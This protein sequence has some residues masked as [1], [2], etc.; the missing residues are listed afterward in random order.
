MDGPLDNPKKRAASRSP[1]VSSSQAKQIKKICYEDNYQDVNEHVMYEPAPIQAMSPSAA[2][3]EY[4]KATQACPSFLEYINTWLDTLYPAAL[5]KKPHSGYQIKDQDCKTILLK[6]PNS[7]PT[8]A[9]GRTKL[10][11][12]A[13]NLGIS[14][15]P[16]A[17]GASIPELRTEE[18]YSVAPTPTETQSKF[19]G[20]LVENPLYRDCNLALNN[21]LL[22]DSRTKL[23]PHLVDLTE[24]LKKGRSSPEPEPS[25]N[26]DLYAL[27]TVSNEAK[28]EEFVRKYVIPP[29]S[30]TGNI[31]RSDRVFVNRKALPATE[32]HARL[33]I[34][35]P[36]LLYGYRFSAFEQDHRT[37]IAT[38]GNFA[39]A[40]GEGL[41]FPF[42]SIEFKG[43]GPSSRGRL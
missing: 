33:S 34:P 37:E 7:A 19:S 26:D 22:L 9:S 38:C 16:N 15:T 29:D 43:D 28:V 21:I 13:A 6:R 42:F 31:Q 1:S 39:I 27:E 4:I 17:S 23:P 2:P 3:L 41:F 40:N 18:G 12:K 35:V 5:P 32:P 20:P 14:F 10:A 25:K 11:G 30:N 24:S 36:D 8:M